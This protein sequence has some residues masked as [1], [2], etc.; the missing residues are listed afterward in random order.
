MTSDQT[1][2]R[3]LH[4]NF[5]DILWFVLALFVVRQG[6]R[7]RGTLTPGDPFTTIAV[8]VTFAW[9]LLLVALAV[10]TIDTRPRGHWLAAGTL[11]VLSLGYLAHWVGLPSGAIGADVLLFSRE[12]AD[13]AAAGQNPY[14]H[15]MGAAIQDHASVSLSRPGAA[16]ALATPT[17]SGGFVP[18]FSYPAGSILWFLP[19]ALTGIGRPEYLLT[20]LVP[21]IGLAGW[22]VMHSPREL[23]ALPLLVLLLPRNLFFTAL[24]GLNDILWVV[25]T[26]VAMGYWARCRWRP[27]GLAYGV[28]VATKQ[29]PWLIAPFLAVWILRQ[30]PTWRQRART[31]VAFAGPATLVFAAV[32]L[33]FAVWNPSAWLRGVFV[34]FGT[35]T[36][37]LVAKG[38]GLALLTATDVYALPHD[39]Y[40]GLL[41]AWSGVL[42][43]AYALYWERLKWVAWLA[44]AL[45]LFVNSRSLPSYLYYCL[46]LAYV[47]LLH[48]TNLYRQPALS[49]TQLAH[50]TRA[51]LEAIT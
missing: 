23:A 40:G 30:E 2:D 10:S 35:N 13:V 50:Q 25:P 41:A 16:T 9:A 14:T 12:A 46:P 48:Q 36:G 27:A 34:A 43:V 4:D 5:S 26:V 29:Q 21:T 49:A 1:F 42:L 44:P 39:Y 18:W 38:V 6:F 51:R 22:L 17:T 31:L 45:L 11:V 15:S 3:L 19:Q 37:P 8:I 47:A 7:V 24:G 28:A 32:N 33:P 20:L